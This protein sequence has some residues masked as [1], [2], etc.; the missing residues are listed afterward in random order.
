MPKSHILM[1]SEEIARQPF[2]VVLPYCPDLTIAS[3]IFENV[4]LISE[5]VSASKLLNEMNFIITGLS[6]S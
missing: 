1:Q 4:A 3:Y 5:D 2:W 6:A